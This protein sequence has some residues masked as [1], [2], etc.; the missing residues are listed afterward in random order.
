MLVYYVIRQIGFWITDHNII[1]ITGKIIPYFDYF[2][3]SRFKDT[4][5]IKTSI[6]LLD[7][8]AH[9]L[10]VYFSLQQRCTLGT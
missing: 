5:K 7:S 3:Q 9:V 8:V 4:A 10:A 2:I 6:T 1:H